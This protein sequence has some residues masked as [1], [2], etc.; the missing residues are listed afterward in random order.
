MRNSGEPR[1][2]PFAV[3]RRTR[4]TTVVERPISLEELSIS[5]VDVVTMERLKTRALLNGRSLDGELRAIIDDAVG[6]GWSSITTELERIRAKFSARSF[7][8]SSELL[9]ENETL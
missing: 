4:S 6:H 1:R 3:G 2:H 5:G 7:P 9:K 8:D